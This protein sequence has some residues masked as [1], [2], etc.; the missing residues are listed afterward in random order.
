MYKNLITTILLLL[1]SHMA[2][3]LSLT[4]EVDRTLIGSNE[5]LRLIVTS[6]SNARNDLDLSQ[7]THQFD[8][9]NS[10]QSNQTSIVNGKVS[11]S[12]QWILIIAPK[13]TGELIIPSFEYNGAYSSAIKITVSDNPASATNNS[14]SNVLLQLS[15]D[16]NS[17]YVQEQILVTFR[18]YYKI[19]LAS[20]DEEGLKLENT[21]IEAVAENTYKKT[22]K[23]A[24]Y[25]VLEK[26]Y[27]LHPQAS[28]DLVIPAQSWRLEKSLRALG[29]GRSGNPYLY[30]RSEPATINVKPIPESITAK[31]WIPSK[32]LTL[33]P[34][35]QQSLVQAKVG[36]PLNLQLTLAAKGL[37]A[38]QLPDINLPNVDGF[39]I[40]SD[41]PTVA[42]TKSTEGVTGTRTNNFAIIPRTAGRFSFPEVRLKWWNTTK[43]QEET[44]ILPKQEIIVANVA[45]EE[46]LP[47]LPSIASPTSS[48]QKP[49]SIWLWQLISITLALICSVLVYLLWLRKLQPKTIS[50]AGSVTTV[51]Q[52]F[53]LVTLENA[54]KNKDWKIFRAEL[55][56]WGQAN[57]NNMSI[58]S[59]TQ[60][61]DN[62][63]ELALGLKQLD[64]FIYGNRPDDAFDPLALVEQLKN[65]KFSANKTT[66][67]ALQPLYKN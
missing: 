6:D 55:I 25:N 8:V 43:D 44:L 26:T 31:S 64:N 30:I 54:A 11:T 57:C 18:L 2:I 60:L 19:P 33:K 15:V 59:L 58:N 7:L 13:E 65:I 39:T 36:E 62:A 53:S 4:A 20:Y 14:N 22:I 17:V 1:V 46:D 63:P 67:H 47:T 21:T 12:I 35:W 5:T 42:D 32:A 56:K 37:T 16:K 23:G 52:H 48:P 29:F 49:A 51:S 28:G 45:I 41:Q 38:A 40:Y 50:T 34:S 9:I 66:K 3:A 10:Q 61:A 27:A 24:T